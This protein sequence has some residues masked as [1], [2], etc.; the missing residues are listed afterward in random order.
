[1]VSTQGRCGMT[2]VPLLDMER[3]RAGQYK[4]IDENGYVIAMLLKRANP[5]HPQARWAA[6][7]NQG[8]VTLSRRTLKEARQAVSNRWAE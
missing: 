7:D 3:A 2:G 8:Q 6:T 4:V 1:M 5:S